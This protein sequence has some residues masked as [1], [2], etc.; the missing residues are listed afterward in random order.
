MKKI[1]I[2]SS[3]LI[4]FLRSEFA[5]AY[6]KHEDN[7]NYTSSYLPYLG[8]IAT[9]GYGLYH[10]F[11]R[12][13]KCIDFEL[14]RKI[15][16]VET[17]A[18]QVFVYIPSYFLMISGL[19]GYNDFLDEQFLPTLA[20]DTSYFIDKLYGMIIWGVAGKTATE[21]LVNK[22]TTYLCGQESD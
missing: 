15:F 13:F 22:L 6:D 21:I 4:F 3:L 19:I 1:L 14:A 11:A 9:A 10:G 5:I 7:Q 20:D 18:G 17:I 16:I 8:M 2:I 12:S